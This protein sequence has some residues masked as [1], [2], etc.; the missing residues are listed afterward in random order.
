MCVDVEGAST[1]PGAEIQQYPCND[2]DAQRWASWPVDG[3]RMF[4][5]AASNLCMT[6]K[7]A[8]LTENGRVI[9]MPCRSADNL[10]QQWGLFESGVPGWPSMLVRHSSLGLRMLSESMEPG[11]PLVQHSIGWD[12]PDNLHASD[13]KI[14]RVPPFPSS[15]PTC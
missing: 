8:T 14:I 13:W 15:C 12:G 7:D 6:V 11:A 5:A 1:L 9:Q 4:R 2:T 3:W 10:E